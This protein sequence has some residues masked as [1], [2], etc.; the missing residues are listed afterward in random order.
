MILFRQENEKEE[1]EKQG[2]GF[3][4]GLTFTPKQ[5]LHDDLIYICVPRAATKQVVGF[6][7]HVS[8]DL[9]TKLKR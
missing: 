3:I 8:F 2:L 9:A 6:V 1:A 4:T 7:T 5:Y